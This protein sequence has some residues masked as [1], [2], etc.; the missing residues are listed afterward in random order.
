MSSTFEEILETYGSKLK[1]VEDFGR[2]VQDPITGEYVRATFVVFV[3]LTKSVMVNIFPL[4]LLAKVEK[5]IFM[6]NSA[7]IL[8]IVDNYMAKEYPELKKALD[9]LKEGKRN[10]SDEKVKEALQTKINIIKQFKDFMT[11]VVADKLNIPTRILKAYNFVVIDLLSPELAEK[12]FEKIY[13][14][15]MDYKLYVYLVTEYIL[16]H[17][18]I[19]QSL[20]KDYN[21]E[22]PPGFIYT[23]SDN[24][25]K[26]E[27]IFD[28]ILAE[29]QSQMGAK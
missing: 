12:M 22:D 18:A 10:N 28:K 15:E 26:K 1:R 25:V 13:K 9:E 19:E 2:S 20:K 3:G 14:I 29:L 24:K 8:K 5:N 21:V 7:T 16:K 17:E 6:P 11:I 4:K 23:A 27:D